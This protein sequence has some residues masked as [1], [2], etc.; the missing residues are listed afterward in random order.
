MNRSE[1]DFQ[2]VGNSCRRNY[3]R[4]AKMLPLSEMDSFERHWL[5]VLIKSVYLHKIG[6]KSVSC[7]PTRKVR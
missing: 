5:S 6:K 3:G 2:P 4:L 7:L 1:L